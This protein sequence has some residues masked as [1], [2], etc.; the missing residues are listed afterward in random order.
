MS[1]TRER[2]LFIG[3]C[4]NGEWLE[5]PSTEYHNVAKPRS[6]VRRFSDKCDIMPNLEID[7]YRRERLRSEGVEWECYVIDSMS[8]CDFIQTLINGYPR[9][10]HNEHDTN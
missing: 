6:H 5:R 7:L 4:A 2:V 10:Q 1:T 9:K 3:G 8:P